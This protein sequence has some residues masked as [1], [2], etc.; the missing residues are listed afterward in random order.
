[1]GCDDFR[2]RALEWHEAVIF[3]G[4]RFDRLR[5]LRDGLRSRHPS[6]DLLSMGMSDDFDEAVSLGVHHVRVGTATFG[7]RVDSS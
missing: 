6:L 2:E 5:A 3:P 1:M 7:R 4:P